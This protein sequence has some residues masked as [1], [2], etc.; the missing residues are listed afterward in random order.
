VQDRRIAAEQQLREREIAKSK[1]IEMAEQD[2]A[3]AIAERTKAQSEAQALA[4]EARA[5]AVRA[6][7]QIAT[8]RATEIAERQKSIDLVEATKVAQRQAIGITVAAEADKR[9]A[10]DRA[11]ALRISAQGESDAEKLRVEAARARYAVDAEGKKAIHEADNTLS[12]D[13]V[14][15]QIKQELMRNL[16][17]IIRESVKPMENIDAIKILQVNGLG[18][19]TGSVGGSGNAATG[20]GNLAE[21]VV[22]SALRYRAQA[23]LMDGLM[24][25]LGLDGS[26]ITGLT[27]GLAGALK[28]QSKPDSTNGKAR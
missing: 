3:I 28:P 11:A 4:D 22:N 25:E 7:E 23:P 2:K 8:A 14:N 19:S 24:Q 15:M 5:I 20:G 27:D 10:E 12:P 13:M 9:A 16:P 17:A 26:Q 18:G 6:E 21:E 1:S